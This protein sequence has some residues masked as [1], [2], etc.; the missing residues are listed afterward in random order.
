MTNGEHATKV[1]Y[2]SIEFWTIVIGGL[3]LPLLAYFGYNIDTDAII[4]SEWIVMVIVALERL[5]LTKTKLTL[6]NTQ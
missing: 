5:F 6:T 4:I 1:W 2:K 3:L